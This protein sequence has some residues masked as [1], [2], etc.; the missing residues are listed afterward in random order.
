MEFLENRTDSKEL[1]PFERISEA[2]KDK[3]EFPD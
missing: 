1:V 3:I 2:E